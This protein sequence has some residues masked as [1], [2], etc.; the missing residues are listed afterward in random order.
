[1]SSEKLEEQSELDRL[2]DNIPETAKKMLVG[3]KTLLNAWKILTKMYGNKTMLANKLKAKLKGISGSGKQDHDV[4]IS[5]AIEVKSIVNS[6]TEMSMQDMLKYDDEY[7]SSIF[8]ALPA[9]DK[10]KWLDFSKESY[11]ST[12]EAMEAFLDNAHER[13]TE[14]KVLLCNYAA[15]DESSIRCRRCQELGH[16]KQ[17]CPK[18]IVVKAA[19]ATTKVDDDSDSEQARNEKQKVKDKIGKCPFC[20]SFHTFKRTKDGKIWPS[21]RFSTCDKFRQLSSKD[22]A[23]VLEK[24]SSCSRCTS[25]LHKKDSSDC[26][27]PKGSCG[28]DKPGG[29]R[30]AN[31]HSRFVCGSG[32]VYCAA[33]KFSKALNKTGASKASDSLTSSPDISAETLMLIEDVRIKAGSKFSSSR[34][35]WDGGS[36]RVLINNEFARE[37][38]LRSQQVKY[39]LAVAGG[40]EIVEEGV[41]YEVDLVDNAG[42]AHAIWGFGLD[43]IIDPPDAVDLQSVR[44]LFPHLPDEVFKMLPKKRIDILVGL[45]FFS[46][47]PD[48][49]QG[50]NCSG[51]SRA[52]H[53]KFS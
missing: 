4:V 39:K 49:G 50:R 13:A 19:A 43:T 45:N 24:N 47:H 21:D 16:K 33:A 44:H 48:G 32:N 10:T 9:H 46:L 2:R 15:G 20:K 8:R 37:Q 41:I 5:L 1:M 12:W 30:C 40:R 31:D 14:T 52:L 25:W 36:N 22:R 29:S 28:A 6:L 27:A 17:D 7:L 26:R 42:H 35:Q 53:S 23:E 51:N 34:T 3:E 18:N 38:K 11:A